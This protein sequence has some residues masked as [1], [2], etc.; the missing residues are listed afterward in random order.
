M[1]S[2][3]VA[4]A[5]HDQPLWWLLTKDV[6]T[7]AALIVMLCAAYRALDLAA[8]ALQYWQGY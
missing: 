1:T 2:Q 4:P 3:D 6:I 8:A 5:K 7:A